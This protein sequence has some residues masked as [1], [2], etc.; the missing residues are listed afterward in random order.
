DVEHVDWNPA[1][2]VKVGEIEPV[3]RA[4]YA[5]GKAAQHDDADVGEIAG[6][7]LVELPLADEFLR[8]RQPLLDLEPLLRED[9]GRMRQPAIFEARWAGDA[10]LARERGAAVGLGLELAGDVA[11]ADAQLHHD[12]R[13]A[14]LRELEALLDHAHDG[15]KVGAGI[16]KP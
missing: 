5:V 16:K 9:D 13:M 15:R 11:G 2:A 7:D 12:R 4:Q 8:R 6:D 10:V 14:R 1:P 3:E